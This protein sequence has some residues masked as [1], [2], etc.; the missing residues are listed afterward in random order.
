LRPF[1]L[2]AAAALAAT[3]C[4]QRKAPTG[5]AALANLPVAATVTLSPA[6]R[7]QRLE[8]FGA[9]VAWYLDKIT[10]HPPSGLDDLLFRDLGLDILRLRNLYQRT[11]DSEGSLA[12]E[13]EILQR[14]TRSLGHPPKIMISSW[15]PPAALKAD[16]REKC[17][18]NKDCTLIR[19]NGRFA[20]DKFADYWHDS[21]VKYAALGI[22]PD[23]VSIENEPSF[24]PPNW[25]G[26]KFDPTESADY[27]GYD[28]ALAAVHARIAK[29]PDLARP[30]QLIGPEVLGIHHGLLERYVKA[31][32]VGLVDGIA[33][34]IYEM[35]PDKIWDWR[36]PGPDS[37]VGEMEA[38]AALTDKPLFQTE[39]GTEGDRGVE[40][41][42]ETAWLI[43]H[44]LTAEGV[45][46]FL[47]WNLIWDKGS[48][49]VN[50]EKKPYFVREHYYAV[51]HYARFTD[52]GYVRIG[53]ASDAPS[54]RASA[55]VSPAGDQITV[56]VLNT[57]K[58][59]ATVHLDAGGFAAPVSAVYRTTFR[60]PGSSDAW[61]SLGPLAAGAAV[62]LPSRSMATL[63]LGAT[64]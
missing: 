43:H 47:Y 25:E 44:S 22:A 61:T 13:V 56:V 12:Q 3:A 10:V 32:D 21:L 40:G 30:T 60:P 39:F 1:P 53:A 45:V 63:V 38:A 62:L 41:G 50:M 64:R 16:H 19:E 24:I 23:W 51:K 48:G 59:E 28:R 6:E 55:F 5:A 27:P 7:H 18:E 17:H 8:G 29:A 15:A 46:A 31:M 9:S 11:D 49:L 54:V 42:F 34:H 58:V 57:G 52:P 14:A 36:N 20:Y 37:F 33:H 4:I 2:V 26:C 35:G